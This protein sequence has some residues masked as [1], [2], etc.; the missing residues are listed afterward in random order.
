MVVTT[1][2]NVIIQLMI[3]YQSSTIH[4]SAFSG[5]Q[6]PNPI[7][8]TTPT[9]NPSKQPQP[10]HRNH[11]TSLLASLKPASAPL[12]TSGKALA[13][14]GEAL[15]DHTDSRD[16]WGGALSA[17]GA[18]VRNAGDCIAQAAA[19]CRFKTGLELVCDEL[20]ESATCLDNAVEKGKDAV[21]EAGGDGDE[22]L[23]GHLADLV[24][25]LAGASRRLE[26]AGEGI[27]K[28]IP[29]PDIGT[30]LYE[31]G[32]HLEA[33]AATIDNLSSGQKDGTLSATKMAYA[34]GAM[35]EAGESLRDGGS[36][37]KTGGNWLK[38]GMM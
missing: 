11:Q 2:V 36:K 37:K 35:M 33:A 12:L 21:E 4:T 18:N 32:A 1:R 9:I 27:M 14:S 8:S 7:I 25:N 26:E 6:T 29:I 31:A 13:V 19:S 38:G 16:L 28:R 24:P 10:H 20:R 34:G 3:I 5:F 30:S 17:V 15:I 23:R 22:V